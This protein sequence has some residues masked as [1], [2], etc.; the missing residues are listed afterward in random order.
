MVTNLISLLIFCGALFFLYRAYRSNKN[1]NSHIAVINLAVAI[2]MAIFSVVGFLRIKNLIVYGVIIIAYYIVMAFYMSNKQKQISLKA[3]TLNSTKT[4][5][6]NT[7]K[8][9]NR[10]I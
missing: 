8:S 7:K 1:N 3:K 9:K 5:I 6:H 4:K 10:N 2:I